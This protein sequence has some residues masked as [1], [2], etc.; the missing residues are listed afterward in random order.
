MVPW[1]FFFYVNQPTNTNKDPLHV[2]NGPIIMS[3]MKALK[4]ALKGLVLQVLAKE[5]IR[6]PLEHQEGALM[7]LIYV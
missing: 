3:K 7:H 2:P 1:F 6:D 5:E 4:E